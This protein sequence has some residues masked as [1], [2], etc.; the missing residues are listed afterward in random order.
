MANAIIAQDVLRSTLLLIT[1]EGN[2]RTG[3]T[4]SA[5]THGPI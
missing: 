2:A 5:V 1:G 4:A 3:R